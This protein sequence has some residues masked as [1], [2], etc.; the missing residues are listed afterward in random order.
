MIVL[1][2]KSRKKIQKEEKTQRKE[3]YMTSGHKGE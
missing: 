3:T 2:A 1:K